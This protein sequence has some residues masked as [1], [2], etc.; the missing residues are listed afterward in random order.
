[1]KKGDKGTGRSP[2]A[3]AAEL[4]EKRRGYMASANGES[5]TAN[6]F[7]DFTAI[8]K[9]WAEGY[10]IHQS[11]GAF[12][13]GESTGAAEA[14]PPTRPPPPVSVAPPAPVAPPLSTSPTPR[15]DTPLSTP[16]APPL[17]TPPAPSQR[18]T[19]RVPPEKAPYP[20]CPGCRRMGGS[21]CA[22]NCSHR[23][24]RE[25]AAR[26][27]VEAEVRVPE[28]FEEGPAPALA[29]EATPGGAWEAR[30]EV[31]PPAVEEPAEAPAKVLPF[32]VLPG[33]EAAPDP[34]EE[35]RRFLVELLEETLAAVRAG[36]IDAGFFVVHH[37]PTHPTGTGWAT[38]FTGNIDFIHRLGALELAKADLLAK[39][40]ASPKG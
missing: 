19:V 8:G 16:A 25:K 11:G 17:S 28:V 4:R 7:P 39:A 33:G 20:R 14:L 21:T 12:P 40:N 2:E 32:R 23:Q 38:A 3:V 31:V 34:H 5:A 1:M 24:Q 27:R 30:P 35:H 36:H 26:E 13:S 37:S 9:A 10:R 6:P 22:N 15:V 18:P 29:V